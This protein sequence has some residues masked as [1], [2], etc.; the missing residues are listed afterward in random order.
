MS[1]FGF[2]LFKLKT[3]N[4]RDIVLPTFRAAV[5]FIVQVQFQAGI[6]IPYKN[7][8]N[9]AASACSLLSEK[10]CKFERKEFI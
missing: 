10:L 1:K 3:S 7:P 6:A 8:C 4:Q 2:E 5:C 9:S